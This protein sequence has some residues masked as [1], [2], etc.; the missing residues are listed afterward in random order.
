LAITFGAPIAPSSYFSATAKCVGLVTTTS[1][2]GTAAS[3]RPRDI[4]RCRSLILPLTSGSPSLSLNSCFASA[5]VIIIWRLNRQI[6]SGASASATATTTPAIAKMP[7]RRSLPAAASAAGSGIPAYAANCA[8]PPAA[9]HAPTE[10]I[11]SAITASLPRSISDSIENR[12][13]SPATGSIR[14][15][16]GVIGLDEKTRPPIA[17]VAPR[18]AMSGTT[19]SGI[20]DQSAS[21]PAAAAAASA[22]SGS[23]VS[24]RSKRSV[25]R[26]R[27][28]VRSAK[29]GP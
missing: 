26:T 17:S 18:L 25:P 3:I 6:C 1:A 16:S 15:R 19:S 8:S 11:A 4:A 27:S 20:T 22:R 12:R 28:S 5:G 2:V 24:A 10:P 29:V 9:I 23:R 7:K 14:E 21:A 13:P